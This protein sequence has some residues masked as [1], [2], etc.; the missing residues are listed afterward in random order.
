MWTRH[1]NTDIDDQMHQQTE[2]NLPQDVT[3]IES[4]WPEQELDPSKHQLISLLNRIILHKFTVS[5]KL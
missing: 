4:V 1:D 2:W 5:Y 3:L